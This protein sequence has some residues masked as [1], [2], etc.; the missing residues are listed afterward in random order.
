MAGLGRVKLRD[1]IPLEGLPCDSYKLS[2]STLSQSLAQYSAAIIQLSTSD[3]ALLRSS[4]ESAPLY[5]QHK[6]S[7]PAADVNDSREWCKTSGYHADP[8]QWK[9]TYDFRPGLTPSS[10]M[11]FPPTGLS[12]VFSMLGR[13]AR[14]ILDAISFYLN[15]RSSPFTQILDNVPLRNREISSSVLSVSCH[16]RSSFQGVTTQEEGQLGMFSDQVD[17]SLVTIVKSDKPGLHVRDFHG[18]WVLVDGD[19][20]PQEAIVY[21]GLA[22]YQATAGYISPALHRTHMGHQQGSLYGQCSLSFKLMPKSM[23]NLNCSE[24]RAAGHEVEAQFQLPLPVDDFMQRSTDQLLNRSNFPTFN[25]PTAQDGS[26]KPMMRRRKSN[27]RSKPLPPSKRLRLE[28]QRVLKERV[29]DIADKKGIKL[30]QVNTLL[31]D[32]ISLSE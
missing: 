5:F 1:L 15:L 4:L 30:S 8:Q 32:S 27:S 9:E 28:A 31:T 2:V 3:G 12:D 17:R 22:L 21:P 20:G 11:E 23:T 13:T 26:M 29:Q 16:A 14:D 6:P 25:F 10:D 7:Y 19:L 18:H 24:M